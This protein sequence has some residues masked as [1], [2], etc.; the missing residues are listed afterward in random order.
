MKIP[1]KYNLRSLRVRWVGTLMTALG[2]G[3]TVALIIV[4]LAMVNGLD[5][6]FVETGDEQTLVVIREGSQNEVNSYFELDKLEAVR[7]LPGVARGADNQ[8][9]AAGETIVVINHP[10]RAGGSSNVTMRGTSLVGISL[11]LDFRL[12]E[13]RIFQKGLREIIVSESIAR[14]FQGLAIGEELHI[15]QGDWKVVGIFTTGGSAYD[16]E[17][18]A[19]Y[20]D[21]AQAWSRP[22]YSSILVQAGSIEAAQQLSKRIGDDQR[23]QLDAMNQREYFRQGTISSIGLKALGFFIATIVGIGSCFAIM[24]MMY[25][26]VMS[27]QQEVATLRALGFRRRSIL[28]SFL[29]EAGLLALLGGILGCLFGSL[30]HGYSAGTSNW[31]SFSEVVFNFRITPQILAQGIIFALAVGFLGGVLPARRA[32]SLKLIDILR[33]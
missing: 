25:G 29:V 6:T 3:L 5:A 17:I 33:E 28:T 27:R 32:A 4:M 24:N 22:I 31:A 16:S 14:R 2:I 10:K 18:W 9:L 26:T 1:L 21:I 23:I 11:R 20:D 7:F 12:I 15:P 8:P 19:D 30:F 13:G